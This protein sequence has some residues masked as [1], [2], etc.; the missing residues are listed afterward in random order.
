MHVHL[1]IQPNILIPVVIWHTKINKIK[2][3][4]SDHSSGNYASFAA[5]SKG[6]VI[7][8][9]HFTLSRNLPGID[10][11]SSLEPNEFLELREGIDSYDFLGN[12]K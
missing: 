6:A 3:G 9:R 12:L 7:I 10:Q 8:E 2:V 5:V 11:S 1:I 4:F